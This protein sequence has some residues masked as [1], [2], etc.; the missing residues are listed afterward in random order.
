[1]FSNPLVTKHPFHIV[2]QS[3]YPFL[4]SLCVL[5]FVLSLI[6]SWTVFSPIFLLPS[7]LLIA[8]VC[9]EWARHI[10]VEATFLGCHTSAVRKGHLIGFAL[11]IV[12]EVFFFLFLVLGLFFFALSPAVELGSI[13]PPAGIHTSSP[14]TVP[15]LNTLILLTSG[16]SVT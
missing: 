5:F 11:F 7:S 16:A 15:L 8:Y 4:T 10:S 1:L 2:S 9:Y 12:R 14:F 6:F 13:W 3:P